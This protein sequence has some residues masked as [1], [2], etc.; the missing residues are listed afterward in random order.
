MGF[1]VS[2]QISPSV[3][4]RIHISAA[5]IYLGATAAYNDIKGEIGRALIGFATTAVLTSGLLVLRCVRRHAL[6]LF[7]GDCGPFIYVDCFGG[8]A[9]AVCCYY[10]SY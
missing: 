2:S 5:C 9:P 8:S 1:L 7:L 10:V 3:I 4:V 6:I